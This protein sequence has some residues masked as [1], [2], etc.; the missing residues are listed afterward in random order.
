MR[1][2][3]LAGQVALVTGGASGIGRAVAERFVAEGAG[4]VVL[5]RDGG[6]LQDLQRTAPPEVVAIEGRADRADDLEGALRFADE[7]F[8]RLDVLVANAGVHDHHRSL[9][10]LT[11]D[12]LDRGFDELF[13]VNVKAVLLGVRCALSRLV[14]TEGSVVITVSPASFQAGGGGALYTASKHAALGLVRQL[15]YELAPR[16]RVNGVAPGATRSHL[17]GP[18]A[19]GEHGTDWEDAAT[20]DLVRSVTPLGFV[21]DP[22]DHA[23]AY[24]LAASRR[25]GRAMTAAVIRT[26]GGVTVPVRAR[27]NDRQDRPEGAL[28]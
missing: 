4:V 27:V 26:D 5:D 28:S 25:D 3:A 9:R 22:A 20:L 21:A 8:G 15:A 10:S 12:E 13:A 17:R 7:R 16:V 1:E 19:L 6:A 18:P 24:V 2:G 23:G 11:P 14:E